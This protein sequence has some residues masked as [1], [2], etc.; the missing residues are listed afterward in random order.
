MHTRRPSRPEAP[1]IRSELVLQMAAGFVAAPG[2][3]LRQAK[4]LIR[5][6]G[7]DDWPVSLFASSTHVGIDEVVDGSVTLAIVNPSAALT[8]AYRGVGRYTSPQPVRVLSVIPSRDQCAL[9]VRSETGLRAYEE[10][11]ER[12][13]P[14]RIGVRGQQDH[15]LHEIFDHILGAADFTLEELCG[16]G[17]STHAFENVPPYRGGVEFDALS[18][19]RLDA[20]FDEGLSGWLEH[21]MELGMYPLPM[22]EQMLSRLTAMGYRRTV[23]SRDIYGELPSDVP[24]LDFS[25]WP[26]FVRADLPDALVL[27]LCA[28][29]DGRR[30]FISWEGDGP[31]PVERMCR[32][33]DEAPFDVPLHP[34]AERFWRERGYLS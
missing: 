26:V 6:Q 13:F 28:A 29:L 34:A 16:W 24:T 10:I 27:Q 31:L 1:T 19:G 3:H 17:G 30:E 18:E 11:R 32:N 9:V 12:R 4:V 8:L 22:S 25:G 20:I 2:Q 5:R 21:A 23:I 33:D 15:Y 14:L 7:S